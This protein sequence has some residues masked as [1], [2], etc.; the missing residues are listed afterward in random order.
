[1]FF[2]PL[3][4]L[5]REPENGTILVFHLDGDGPKQLDMVNVGE[6]NMMHAFLD[7]IND[8][9]TQVETPSGRG[10]LW[11]TLLPT[12]NSDDYAKAWVEHVYG[13]T[14]RQLDDAYTYPFRWQ[15]QRTGTHEAY[16][17]GVNPSAGEKTYMECTLKC[18]Y[19]KKL[20]DDKTMLAFRL[21]A[22]EYA[23]SP[24]LP[25]PPLLL[26]ASLAFP[27]PLA[28][29]AC[30]A[31]LA[32]LACLVSLASSAPWPPLAWASL[33]PLGP[34]GLLGPFGLLSFWLCSASHPAVQADSSIR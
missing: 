20:L 32:W 12:F 21:S 34:L 30:L 25:Y 17:L 4:K 19:D 31:S 16:S 1:M 33:A 7:R 24:W 10:P 26:S 14:L 11:A 8:F 3:P 29:L 13:G 6:R 9:K 2:A 15:H 28:P 22:Q 23:R 27:A 18:W 5:P